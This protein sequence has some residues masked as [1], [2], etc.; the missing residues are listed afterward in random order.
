MMQQNA[1]I[2]GRNA[3]VA[4]CLAPILLASGHVGAQNRIKGEYAQSRQPVYR[5]GDLNQ[6]LS[7][8]CRRGMFKQ[9]KPYRLSIGYVGERGQ[10]ITGIAQLGWNLYDPTGA[11]EPERTYHF[12]NQGYSNCRV[13]VAVTPPPRQR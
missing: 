10:G 1:L 11:A 5:V 6:K 3:L 8:L 4:M 7:A 9:R 12:F 13:Y 2:C